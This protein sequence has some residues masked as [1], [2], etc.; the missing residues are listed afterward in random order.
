[1][2]AVIQRVTNARVLV[3]GEVISEIGKGLCVLIGICNNDT[4]E[5][6]KYISRKILNTRLFEENGKRWMKSVKDMNYEILCIS[7][8]TLYYRL[9]GNKPDFHHAMG[10]ERAKEM[11][12]QLLATLGKDHNPDKIKDGVFG[13][14]MNVQIFN[15]GPVTIEIESPVKAVKLDDKE[16]ESSNS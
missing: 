2:K 15:D 6:L 10:G 3:N 7:Q 12:D 4:E 13:A 9:K 14:M 5:D 11:Y 16:A 1:M 8:F